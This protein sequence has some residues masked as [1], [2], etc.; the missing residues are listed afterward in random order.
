MASYIY[1][2]E[3]IHMAS[4]KRPKHPDSEPPL[5]ASA[6]SSGIKMRTKKC[7]EAQP[8][9]H[10]RQNQKPQP[11]HCCSRQCKVKFLFSFK[12]V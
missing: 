8:H 6:A 7:Q 12:K 4:I 9:I 2:M 11:S 5:S 1:F 10:E 3:Y